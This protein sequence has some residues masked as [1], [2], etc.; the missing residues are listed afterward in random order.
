[1]RTLRAIVLAIG[2]MGLAGGV[3]ACGG[4]DKKGD[5]TPKKVEE[6]K[7]DNPCGPKADEPKKDAPKADEP[8]KDETKPANPCGGGEKKDPAPANP[9]G[10]G[11]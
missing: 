1:M 3:V 5:T 4:G 9:C 7:K 10:G 11:K 2:M 8:K 6:P